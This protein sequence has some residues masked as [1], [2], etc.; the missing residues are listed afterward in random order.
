MTSTHS[1][2]P[3]FQQSA[4]LRKYSTFISVTLVW[5][6]VVGAANLGNHFIQNNLCTYHC[7]LMLHYK[8]FHPLCKIVSYC[9][10]IFVTLLDSG[11]W[12]QEIF[13]KHVKW[14]KNWHWAKGCMWSFLRLLLLSTHITLSYPIIAVLPYTTP[15]AP[16]KGPLPSFLMTQVT[17][18]REL[19]TC[20][21]TLVCK[22]LGTSN[23]RS[24]PVV[25]C[26]MNLCI[27]TH[28]APLLGTT[29]STSVWS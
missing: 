25:S 23:C 1:G 26:L 22:V 10:H 18:K 2:F 7:T 9:Q 20:Y 6:N 27:N 16:L 21:K 8:K 17:P 15:I 3:Y 12:A 11:K 14:I 28:L 5:V 4:Q 29:N 19:C 13:C 24:S